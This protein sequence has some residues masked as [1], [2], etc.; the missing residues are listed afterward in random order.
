MLLVSLAAENLDFIAALYFM[1]LN[2]TLFAVKLYIGYDFII[3][4]NK[5]NNR[6]TIFELQKEDNYFI[7]W[8]SEV[9][10]L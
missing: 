8:L 3:A 1:F 2:T 5:L 9:V 10:L 4:R 7:I 6:T